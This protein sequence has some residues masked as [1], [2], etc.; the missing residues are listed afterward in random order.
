MLASIMKLQEAVAVSVKK[1]EKQVVEK[2]ISDG[3]CEFSDAML[4]LECFKTD[5]LLAAKEGENIYSQ[6]LAL[7]SKIVQ[8]TKEM[9]LVRQMRETDKLRYAHL[10]GFDLD[11]VVAHKADTSRKVRRATVGETYITQ[12]TI[13]V[14]QERRNALRQQYDAGMAVVSRII[15]TAKDLVDKE[16]AKLMP[17]ISEAKHELALVREDLDNAEES[18]KSMFEE[19][20]GLEKEYAYSIIDGKKIY[21]KESE[22]NKWY[23]QTLKEGRTAITE[24]MSN[25]KDMHGIDSIIPKDQLVKAVCAF[26]M[27]K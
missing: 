9:E 17:L 12:P 21:S 26:G 13:R 7:Y 1:S 19:V 3:F 8:A 22:Y 6:P 23:S 18:I 10:T 20:H 27:S 24:F 4:A 2:I 5:T 14:E 16:K 11:S 25:F 15:N